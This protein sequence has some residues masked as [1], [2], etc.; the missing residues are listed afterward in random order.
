MISCGEPSGDLYAGAL[1]TEIL[2]LDPSA[3][4][5][6][7]RRRS[8]ARRGRHAG[9]RLQRPVGHRAARGRARAAAHLCD[10]PAAGARRGS[11]PPRRL[12]RDRFP[13]LQLHPRPRA[14]QAR[15]AGRL[16]HQPAALGVAPRP[17]EDDAADRRS[18]ARHLS[19]RRGR[20]T[21]RRAC[22]CSGSGIRCSTWRTPPSRA[23]GFSRATASIRI[24][25][26]SRCCRAAGATSC[27]QSSRI[28]PRA[29]VLIRERIPDVQFIVARAPHLDDELFAPLAAIGRPAREPVGRRGA[30]RRRARGRRRGARRIRDGDGAGARCTSARWSSCIACRR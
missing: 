18:R 23:P 6:R 14:R 10:L 3:V 4:D 1:A 22:R 21:A 29:A 30:D 2:R 25:R 15:R 17:D 27:A 24:G 13:G 16:L 26:S 20:S 7:L 19:V 9:R 5:H 28:S 11:D 8:P 12:R